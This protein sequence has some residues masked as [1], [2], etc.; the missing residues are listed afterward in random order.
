VQ[1]VA[2][3]IGLDRRIGPKF[4]HAG[5]GY[6]G[7]CFPKDT[8]ALVHAAREA[9]APLRIV[10]AVVEANEER[11]AA[12][13]GRI[14]AAL[15]GMAAG[16]LVAVLGVTFKPNTDDMRE[17]PSLSIIPALQ[18]A[19]AR[20]RAHDP[21]GM[22][23][24][25]KLLSDVEWCDGPYHAAERADA[26]VIITEW[27]AYRAL[28]L[29]RLRRMMQGRVFVDLRNIYKAGEVEA[30]GFA[31]HGLGLGRAVDGERQRPAEGAAGPRQI[32]SELPV[33]TRQYGRKKR[34]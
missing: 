7:S 9:G 5:P 2:R 12:M 20:I 19:G 18:A 17:A 3:G 10:Q 22:A 31:Y 15:G 33:P 1:E 29:A 23:E 4:L 30:A 28:D 14:V 34:A 8:R 32:A 16:R 25:A 11:K 24:A 26:L 21:E 6:G 13:A 27:D